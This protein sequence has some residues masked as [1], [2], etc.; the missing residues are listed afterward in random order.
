LR[1]SKKFLIFGVSFFFAFLL[2]SVLIFSNIGQGFDTWIALAINSTDFGEVFTTLMILFAEYGR[3][4]LWIP[5]VGLMFFLGNRETKLLALELVALFVAG[6]VIGE[7]LK[8]VIFRPRPFET[9]IGIVPRV[10]KEV[11]SS[12]PS[13]HALIVGIGAF[14]SLTKFKKRSI[15]SLLTIEAATVCYSRIYVGMHYPLDV[16]AGIFLSISIVFTGLLFF[17]RYLHN[18]LQDLTSFLVKKFKDGPIEL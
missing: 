16:I 17:E 14:F 11:D 18:Q 4:Y 3:E 8:L 7:V 6:I 13:G 5:V 10:V 9:I 1:R 12:Y 2:I 15:A